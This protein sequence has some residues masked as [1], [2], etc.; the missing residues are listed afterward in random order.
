MGS[1]PLKVNK[2]SDPTTSGS[3]ANASR[4][5]NGE[6]KF[7]PKQSLAI[8]I[9]L[10]IVERSLGPLATNGC[11]ALAK[12]LSDYLDIPPANV[13]Q[14]LPSEDPG[15]PFTRDGLSKSLYECARD[16]GS[17][18]IL[19]VAFFGHGFTVVKD[20]MKQ[21]VLPLFGHTT[22]NPKY[23]DIKDIVEAV[24]T[25]GEFRGKNVLLVLDCCFS[26]GFAESLQCEE[27]GDEV[28]RTIT[29]CSPYQ[30]TIQLNP[31]GVS[32]FTYFLIDAMS[33][34]QGITELFQVQQE[35]SSGPM[36]CLCLQDIFKHICGSSWALSAMHIKYNIANRSL[37][38]CVITPVVTSRL[39]QTSS[40]ENEVNG[41]NSPDGNG[42]DG[43]GKFSLIYKF[44]PAFPLVHVSNQRLSQI[45]Y[46]WLEEQ[47]KPNG[48]LAMLQDRGHITLVGKVLQAAICGLCNSVA[49]IHLY[50]NHPR[51]GKARLFMNDLTD[52]IDVV[53]AFTDGEVIVRHEAVRQA[54]TY[55]FAAYKSANWPDLSELRLL[56]RLLLTDEL[57]DDGKSA[58]GLVSEE[59]MHMRLHTT[60][61]LPLACTTEVP[62]LTTILC[63]H[64]DL[65]QISYLQF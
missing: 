5:D 37:Q 23:L 20:G 16:V 62:I 30:T 52:V 43:S 19:V 14:L 38:G 41:V 8:C 25:K 32:Q 50:E 13:K 57:K 36:V 54:L 49:A 11:K 34:R 65:L 40:E 31:L 7:D 12:A 2:P 10:D 64:A 59:D 26:A 39:H 4:K 60:S 48:P 46:Q 1:K 61:T 6:I 53:S 47:A 63:Q 35:G 58:D 51:N 45:S 28:F 42:S 3:S 24:Q 17:E 22:E 27:R 56:Y 18:G 21:A 15:R 33:G 29:A 44:W 55:Y 9:A